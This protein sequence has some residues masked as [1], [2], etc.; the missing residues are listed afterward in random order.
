LKRVYDDINEQTTMTVDGTETGFTYD[1]WG[2]MVARTMGDHEHD[3]VYTYRYGD[4]L[5]GITS[6]FPD[7]VADFGMNYDGLGRWRSMWGDS[8]S[9]TNPLVWWRYDGGWN[10]LGMYGQGVNHPVGDLGI[11]FTYD[12]ASNGGAPLGHT[13]VGNPDTFINSVNDRLGSARRM[14]ME[15]TTPLG[16]AELTPYGEVYNEAP[17]FPT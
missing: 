3:A 10:A 5:Y 11:R 14:R 12:P 4:K 8:G 16:I 13:F 9:E 17:A 1:D 6:D 2:R 7:E 15:D